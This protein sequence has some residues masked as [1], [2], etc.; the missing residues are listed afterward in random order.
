MIAVGGE[1]F[2]IKIDNAVRYKGGYNV[3][4]EGEAKEHVGLEQEESA[5][6]VEFKPEADGKK[7]EII[8]S[9][10]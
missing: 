10:K 7:V 8:V 4:V 5:I 3:V 2:E 1:K 6:K 9:A